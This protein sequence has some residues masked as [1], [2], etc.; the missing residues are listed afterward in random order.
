MLPVRFRIPV[1]VVTVAAFMLGSFPQHAFAIDDADRA[2]AAQL[3]VDGKKLMEDGKY[4]D[5]CPK[6]EESQRLDP[7]DGTLLRLAWCDEMLGKL[8]TSWALFREGLASAKKAGNEAR[9]KF[10]TEHIAAIEPKLSKVTIQVSPGAAVEGLEVR[11]DGKS[12]SKSE[13]N[14]EFPVDPGDHTLSAAA[15]GRQTWTTTIGVG[16]NADRRAVEI[17]QLTSS[18][19][20]G[21]TD[22][23]PTMAEKKTPT[24]VYVLAGTGIVLIGATVLARVEVG[25]AHDDRRAQCLT[26]VAPSCDDVGTGKIRA[27]EAVSFVTGGLAAVSLGAALYLYVSAPKESTAPTTGYVRVGPTVGGIQIQGAF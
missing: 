2:R 18:N 5:A 22:A 4:A 13:W 11:W 16:A 8:A 27:W 17:P 25:S 14:S 15:P 3:F 26:E 6:L 9:I 23:S 7:G 10:A 21:S 20:T 12:L 19:T 24:M 1:A